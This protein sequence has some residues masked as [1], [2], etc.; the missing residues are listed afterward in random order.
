MKITIEINGQEY[1]AELSE[2]AVEALDA[3][4]SRSGL[5][6]EAALQQAIVNENFLEELTR[7]GGQLLVK[8]GD[9]LRELD[10]EPA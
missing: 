3:I 10:Y 8:K 7:N 4:V 9:K 6:P 5:S 1:T 2:A